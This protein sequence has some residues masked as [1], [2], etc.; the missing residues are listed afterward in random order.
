MKDRE[1]TKKQLLD[2]L[3]ETSQRVAEL[4]ISQNVSSWFQTVTC[5]VPQTKTEFFPSD[6]AL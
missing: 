2:E 4:D 5:L 6:F 1:K 3:L